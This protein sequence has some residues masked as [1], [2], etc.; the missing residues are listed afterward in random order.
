MGEV[1]STREGL[2]GY[3]NEFAIIAGCNALDE[4]GALVTMNG[5]TWLTAF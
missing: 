4:I 3:G 1:Y 2:L 5:Y